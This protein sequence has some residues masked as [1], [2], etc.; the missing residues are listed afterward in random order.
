ML[1]AFMLTPPCVAAAPL[2]P[3]TNVPGADNPFILSDGAIHFELKAPQAGSV[4]LAG[5]DGLGKGP[6]PLTKDAS[7]VWST[8]LAAPVPGFHYYWFVVDGVE[9]N[10]P[11]SQAFFG[12]GRPTSGIE[13]PESGA[14]YYAIKD[15]PHGEV[16]ERWYFSKTTGQWRRAMVY[17]PPGYDQ[18]IKTRYPVLLLQHGYGE[19]ETGWTR[20]GRAQLILDNLIAS[21][22]AR[23]MIVVMDR[24]SVVRPGAPPLRLGPEATMASVKSAFSTFE[25]VIVGDLLPMVDASYRTIADRNHRAMAGL[26]MGGMQTLFIALRHLDLFAYIASFSGPVLPN[27]DA[28]GRFGEHPELQAFDI[29]TAYEGAFADPAAFNRRVRLLWLGVGTQEPEQFLSSI[30]GASQALQAAGVRLQYF[31][32][33]GTAHEWQTWRRDLKDLLPRLFP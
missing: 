1:A 15:V 4:Q 12:Y 3:Q 22:S 32:S 10:D 16:R 17:T 33:Q 13:V 25:D 18:E 23:P 9:A 29:R 31:E 28:P 8:T 19:D 27:M 2:L 5:G 11:G 30:R 26:S 20:Q 21:G 14:D 6:F 24:G 7:G